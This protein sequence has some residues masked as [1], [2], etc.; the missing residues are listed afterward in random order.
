M[1]TEVITHRLREFLKKSESVP[2]VSVTSVDA[3]S[4]EIPLAEPT[5][6]ALRIQSLIGAL[7]SPASPAP[8]ENPKPIASD[9]PEPALPSSI[10]PQ[11]QD[12]KL[13]AIL[14]SPTIM[15]GS[16]SH[17]PSI[18]SILEGLGPR[19]GENQ[20]K[21]ISNGGTHGEDDDM[22]NIFSD[23]SSVMVYSPLLPT[24]DSLVELA[25]SEVIVEEEELEVG[26]IEST[27]A[28]PLPGWTWA[29]ILPDMPSW[30]SQIRAAPMAVVDENHQSLTPRSKEIKLRTHA[31]RVWV[32]SKDKLSIQTMW[33][34]YRL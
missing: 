32:P 12:S 18:W 14:S 5:S 33:W 19:R 30:F 6:V 8:I 20:Q 24:H 31:T 10:D 11:I 3:P 9:I 23:S 17:R 15:N 16:G 1:M 34:G 4:A 26:E 21:F 2:E 7:P 13:V 29:N 27:S 22:S 28:P 25:D